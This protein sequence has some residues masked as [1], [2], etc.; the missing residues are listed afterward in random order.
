VVD[1]AHH[2]I[3]DSYLRVL[4]GFAGTPMI[5]GFT[6]TPERADSKILGDVWDKIV[7]SR[8]ILEM[9]SA[10][11]LCDLK[12]KQVRLKD[13]DLGEVRIRQGDY[14]AGDLGAAMELANAP[15]H[16][17]RAYHEY[18]YGRKAI[19]FLP[20]VALA[21]EVNL[22]FVEAN[23]DSY[24][25]TG[26]DVV[27]DRRETLKAF[28]RGGASVI[29]NCAVLTEGYDEPSVNCIIIARPTKSR[30]FY[31]QMIGRGTRRH[32]GKEDCL[33]LD[34]VGATGLDLVTMAGLFKLKEST[35]EN[36]IQSLLA[37]VAAHDTAAAAEGEM[38]AEAVDVLRLQRL[39]W[40]PDGPRFL[41][42]TGEET[43]MLF[44]EDLG[45]NIA[46]LPRD[47]TLSRKLLYKGLTL[48]YAQGVA[49]DYV[50]EL[51][52]M[53]LAKAGAKWRE[54]GP[55]EKQEELLRKWG[56]WREG[57]TKGQASDMIS[58]RMARRRDS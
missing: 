22:A 9:I 15:E 31:T 51:G 37:R 20:T 12:A 38:V 58:I 53:G 11:Y 36:G 41:L 13:L 55:S 21:E 47:R 32:P 5:A 17:V 33:I 35:A 52:A 34:M 27:G 49:E 14:D 30:P 40:I 2:A 57:L 56:L 54:A 28:S 7:Y 46:S 24:I 50:K 26:D 45:W 42:S 1:E 18:A 48:E 10:G 23:I 16:I 44:P 39:H 3:A 29:S 19:C 6:A 43:L 25:V 4:D 8:T